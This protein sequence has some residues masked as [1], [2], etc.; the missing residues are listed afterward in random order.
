MRLSIVLCLGAFLSHGAGAAQE[1]APSYIPSLDDKFC[2]QVDYKGPRTSW[3]PNADAP[4][5]ATAFFD[6]TLV[7]P[8]DRHQNYDLTCLDLP[9]PGDLGIVYPI[10]LEFRIATGDGASQ[11]SYDVF[12][13]DA[14]LTPNVSVPGTPATFGALA[15]GAYD[16]QKG[17]GGT[18]RLTI[19]RPMGIVFG[20]TGNWR[21]RKDAT[22][23]Y[24]VQA[25]VR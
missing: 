18:I 14:P 5:T 24:F 8:G 12:A 6:G 20:A 17:R 22:N 3:L 21:S 2:S 1:D 23:T 15:R 4:G 10:T 13:V 9:L 25:V 16:I 19:K 7:A 11:A